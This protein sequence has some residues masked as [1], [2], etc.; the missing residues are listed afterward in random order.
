[1]ILSKFNSNYI[2]NLKDKIA[3]A[4]SNSSHNILT[5]VDFGNKASSIRNTLDADDLT[6]QQKADSISSHLTQM[7]NSYVT[8]HNQLKKV[9]NEIKTI[10][11]VER[12]AQIRNL[13][14]RILTTAFVGLT[15][16]GIYFVANKFNIPMPLLR[17]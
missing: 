3:A 13:V 4:I 11:Q 7:Q 15:I 1:M 9:T 6:E 10:N 2:D 17:M 14:F 12:T 5:S 16:M 8:V